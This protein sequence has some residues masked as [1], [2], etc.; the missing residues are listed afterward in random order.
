MHMS[1]GSFYIFHDEYIESN[2]KELLMGHINTDQLV[3][4]DKR[5]Y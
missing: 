3:I 5:F 4:T 2:Q 1:A